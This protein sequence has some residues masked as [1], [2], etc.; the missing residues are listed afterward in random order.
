MNQLSCLH[1]DARPESLQD[2]ERQDIRDILVSFISA[3]R[4]A[5]L[6]VYSYAVT[7]HLDRTRP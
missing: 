4:M 5:P 7:V 6:P 1:R 3:K 2:D